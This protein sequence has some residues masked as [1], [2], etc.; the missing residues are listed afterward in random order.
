M[1]ITWNTVTLKLENCRRKSNIF[2]AID[3]MVATR[4]NLFIRGEHN[5][6]PLSYKKKFFNIIKN[7]LEDDSDFKDYYLK[8][9]HRVYAFVNDKNNVKIEIIEA[10]KIGA[11]YVISKYLVNN[12]SLKFVTEIEGIEKLYLYEII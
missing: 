1:V 6:Y 12:L 5:L 11:S 4:M 8:W 2:V 7:E 9:G 10:K 3:P